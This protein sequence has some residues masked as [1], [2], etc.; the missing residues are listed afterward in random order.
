MRQFSVLHPS[1][2]LPDLEDQ[3]LIAQCYLRLFPEFPLLC[4]SFCR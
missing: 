2:W 3:G 1:A 4:K